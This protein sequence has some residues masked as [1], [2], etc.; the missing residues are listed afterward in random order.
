MAIFR[1][2]VRADEAEPTIRA[3]KI[4]R[5]LDERDVNIRAV[6]ARGVAAAVFEEQRCRDAFLPETRRAF[7]RLYSSGN[8]GCETASFGRSEVE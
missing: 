7:A 3:E 6:V 5:T 2:A 1:P 8:C 4:A